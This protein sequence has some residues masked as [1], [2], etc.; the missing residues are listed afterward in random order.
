MLNLRYI[1][2]LIV[3]FFSRFKMLL[4]IGIG[5][6]VVIFFLLSL[7]VPTIDG[8]KTTRIGLTGRYTLTNLPVSILS[9]VG[10]GLTKL[11]ENGNILPNLASS[12]ETTDKGKT[13]TFTI[14]DNV[15]WQDGK[16]VTSG[17][18]N[19][20]FSDVTIERPNDKTII[21]K[22]Q[23]AY[24][25]F[26]SVVSRP[27][28]KSGLLGTGAWKVSKLS[29]NGTIVEQISLVSTTGEK[30]IYKFYPAEDSTKL[31][32]ELGKVDAIEDVLDPSPISSW[33]KVKIEKTV[34]TG[35]YVAVF[36]N[37]QDKLLVEKN[38][39]QAL[40]Y[41]INKDNLPGIRA[42]SPISISSWAYNPQV[43]PY[44]YDMEKAK[45][46]INEYKES[47]KLDKLSVNLT[48]APVLL[49]EAEKIAKDW[50]AIGVEVNLQ[51]ISSIPTDYQALLAI[52][53]I[54]EDPDQYSIWH[55]T[56]TSTNVTHY[57]DARIDKLL[58]D[59]RSQINIEDRKK[60]YFDFQRFLVED[61]PAA[62]LYYPETFKISR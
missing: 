35:E 60:T 62:F 15:L 27:T 11:D 58:E 30:I 46:M 2:R 32:F 59:G 25:A 21:F 13:W 39:R 57:Q 31:A 61:S 29:L 40:S 14:K 10:D 18:I 45:T 20:Q 55:S 16:S 1:F 5:V 7:V 36:F 19:Y 54:P 12:W 4:F 24:S 44:D 56:Q 33:P 51:V 52:F 28:F 37:T 41:A 50:R 48:T 8:S 22:L 49:P 6:G 47:S 34:S 38:I 23:N 42:I 26:P 9:M 43:K 3:A 17:T 53:D